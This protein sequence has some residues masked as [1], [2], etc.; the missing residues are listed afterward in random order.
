MWLSG[1]AL[2]KT[3]VESPISEDEYLSQVEGD[4]DS[5]VDAVD[6]FQEGFT[7]NVEYSSSTEG[8][9]VGKGMPIVTNP[10]DQVLCLDHL[11]VATPGTP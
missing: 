6:V 8:E 11:H 3:G 9:T 4:D 1:Y 10:E 2:P 7:R 5:C